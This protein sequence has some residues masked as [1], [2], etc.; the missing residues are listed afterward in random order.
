MNKS[1]LFHDSWGPRLSVQVND[2]DYELEHIYFYDDEGVITG[3]D[4]FEDNRTFRFDGE[5]RLRRKINLSRRENFIIKNYHSI[6]G[7]RYDL[8]I[9]HENVDLRYDGKCVENSY[10]YDSDEV[11]FSHKYKRYILK[12]EIGGD[13][14]HK[15]YIK[16]L[17][18]KKDKLT[19]KANIILNELLGTSYH[20]IPEE[21]LE[22][23]FRKLRRVN[24]QLNRENKRLIYRELHNL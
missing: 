17:S 18:R 9:Y 11:M 13:Y 2:K 1:Y 15:E 23:A 10:Y 3:L 7:R 21:E 8:Y 20:S 14:V 5:T 16:S 22:Q 4:Y 24:E 6:R 12:D 19:V